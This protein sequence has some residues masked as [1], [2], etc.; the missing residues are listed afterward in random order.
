MFIDLHTHTTCSDGTLTPEALV[1]YAHTKGLAAVAVTDHDTVAGN[2]RA[3]HEGEKTRM[4][5][6]PGVEFSA[7]CPQGSLHIL[8]Y[9]VD[10]GSDAIEKT[11]NTL[12][13]KRRERNLK[14]IQ[15]L[16]EIGYQIN[17][18]AFYENAY[19]GRPHIAHELVQSGHVKTI[20]EAFQK[21][22]KRGASAYVKREKLSEGETVETIIKAKG[23]PV[24]AH[25]ITVFGPEQAVRR[26]VPLGLKGIEVYYPTH[27][28]KDT[29]Y[30]EELSRKYGLVMTG[31][32]DFHGEHKPE[33]DL[34]CMKVPAHLLEKLK[35]IKK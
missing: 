31:G 27:S 8:G 1:Q 17:E 23:V 30:F 12:Q 9:F 34:G 10:S 29:M 15:K 19:L 25:P 16:N 13:K 21:F 33:I 32:S 28:Q 22:L 14:I 6:I 4:E 3:V 11:V 20:E 24:L 7:S 5:V 18:D 26:L 2:K 35:E